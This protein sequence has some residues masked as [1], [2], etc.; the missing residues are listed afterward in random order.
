MRSN[1]SWRHRYVSLTTSLVF[2]LLVCLPGFA[3]SL[4]QIAPPPVSRV[5]SAINDSQVVTLKGHVH[6][7]AQAQFDQG[8]V[9]DSTAAEHVI[10]MLQRSPQQEAA[11]AV[12]LDQLHNRNSPMFH[13]WL[14]AEEFGQ[15]FGPTTS[16]IAKLTDWLQQKGFTIE[17]VPPGR[18][19]ITISG[20]AGQMRQAFNAQ[21]H[22]LN[23]NGEKHVAVLKDPTIP[24]AL[25]PVVS[26]FR[27]L[28]DWGPKPNLVGQSVHHKNPATG[29][30]EKV[31]G[32]KSVPEFT[33]NYSGYNNYDVTPQDWY[34][35]YNA[36][37][38]YAAGTTGAGVTIAVLEETEVVNQSDIA[39]FRSAFGLSAYPGTPNATQGGINWVYGPGNGCS[40]PAKP[41]S[42]GEEGEALLDAEWSGAIAPNAIV[43]FVA[44]NSTGSGIGTYGT[45]LA[46][47]YVAN[48][49]Y[50]TVSATSLSYGECETSAGSTGVAYYKN[51]WQQM[52]AEGITATVSSGD[53]GS[54]G[55]DQNLTYQR[56]NL[57]TNAMSSSPY[58][59]SA[60]GTDFSDEYQAK[61]ATP[62]TYWSATNASGYS[63]A[64]SYIPEI[65]WGAYCANPL[66][67]SYLQAIGNTTYTTTYTPEYLCANTNMSAYRA[68]VGGSGGISQFNTI[69]SW[70]SVYG[71]GT[72]T[73]SNTYRNEPDL[74]FF[75]SSGWWGHAI[76]YCQS[77]AGYP[78]TYSNT[79]D[80]YY[81]AAGGTSFVA[82]AITGLMGL[83]NQKYGRQGVANYTLYNLAAQEYGSTGT[84]SGSI[85]NCS[86]SALGA[87]VGSTCVFRDVA[88]DTPCLT[89]STMCGTANTGFTGTGPGSGA[90]NA[91]SIS[92]DIVQSCK[93]SSVTNCYRALSTHTY[94]LSAV[95]SHTT[96]AAY[97]TAQGYDL[98]TGLGSVNVANLVNNWTNVSSGFATTTSLAGVPTS[99]SSSTPGT[100]LTAT[101]VATGR[102]GKVAAT[103]LVDFYIDSTSGTLLGTGTLTPTCTGSA[104][105]ASCSASAS[106]TLNGDNLPDGSNN[107]IAYFPGDGAND[108]PSTSAAA[109]VSVTRSSQTITF[110]NPGTQLAGT[111]SLNL[112]ATSTSGLP[113]T[114]TVISGAA[115]VSGSV[116]TITG[117]GPITVEADQAAGIGTWYDAAAPVQ[118]TF[119]VNSAP[120]AVNVSWATPGA[121]TYPT[122]LSATQL[123]AAATYGGNPVPGSFA[124]TPALGTVLDGG[125]Q[126]LSVTFTPNNAVAYSS[127]TQTVQI[128]V[129]ATGQTI[130]FPNPGPVTFGVAPITLAA[131]SDSGL[132]IT[133]TVISGPATI[134]VTHGVG[135]AA[136]ARINMKG[137]SPSTSVVGSTLT[138]TGAG[139]VVVEADQAGDADYTAA[140]AVQDSIVVNQATPTVVW[141]TPAAITY[142]TPLSGTQLNATATGVSGALAGS[143]NYTPVLGAVLDAG[144][145]TLSVT[146][147]PSDTTDYTT[148]SL[149]VSLQVNAAGQTITFPNPGP[150]TFGVAP[151]TLAATSDSGLPITYTVISGPATISVTHGVGKAAKGRARISA[152]GA[153]PADSVV[154]STLTIT[155]AGTV[156]VEADQAGDADYTA[157]AA[158]QDSI[159]VNQATPTV[160]WPTPAAITYPA[161]LS[162]TQLNATATGVSG[163]LA[164]SFNYTPAAGSV[165]DAGLQTLS[166][167][168]TPSDTTDYTTASLTV[169]LQVNAAG[170]T[171][172]FPNPGPVT[173]GV[174]PIT[175]AATSD[176]GLPI[177]YTVV[178]GPATISVTHGVGKAAKAR[179]NMKGAKPAVS[180]V[181]STLTITGA[182]TVVVEADQAGD[183][184]YTAAAPVQD[185]IVV[186]Q[187]TP[188]VVWPTPAA[189]TY[190]TPLSGT[191]L[192]ATATGVSGALAGSFNY[193]PVSGAV[194]DVGSQ[195]LSVT[196][197]PSDTTDYTTASLTVSLQV[198]AAGQTITFPNPGTQRYGTPLTVSA[199]ASS[200]LAVSFSSSTP[201]ICS[202]S[203]GTVNFVTL[204]TCTVVATQ[205]GNS[206]YLSA[207]VS[208]SFLVYHELQTIT[209]GPI[210]SQVAGTPV[211]LS[212]TATSGLPVSFAST[213][214][215]VCTVSGTTASLVGIGTCNIVASQVGNYDVLA[216]PQVSRSLYV[217]GAAQS[218]NLATV[219]T[220]TLATGTVNVT[221]SASSGLPVT[222]VSTTPTTCSVSGTTVTMIAVGTCGLEASAAG[223]SYYVA[224]PNVWGHFLITI[225]TQTI[226]FAPLPAVAY[227][228][229]PF[230]LTATASSSLPVSY[231][232]TPSTVCTVSGAS[233]SLTGAG[234]CTITAKQGGNYEYSAAAPVSQSF[235]VSNEAQT[236]TFN[237]IGSQVAG[238]PLT[239]SATASSGLPVSFAPTAATSAVCSVSGNTANFTAIGTCIIVAT[240]P[241]NA[242]IAAAPPVSRQFY[243]AGAAQTISLQTVPSTSLTAGT[244]NL[245]V[246]ASSGLAVTVVS[247]TPSTCSV[248]GY[249]VTLKAT[250]TCGLEA[251]VPSNGYYAAA[252]NVWSNF[253]VTR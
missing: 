64:L 91:T 241:G 120:V 205:G 78:C 224:A 138:I 15:N 39:S 36:N 251:S 66:F 54:A 143:F 227:S 82:P 159:V 3:Q 31:M 129:N 119:S 250:G 231:T 165:L 85:A 23:V 229:T 167:T 107:I 106:L 176:S 43:D 67:V 92:S 169:S 127:E 139:T 214:S 29:A 199:S 79:A 243:V 238:T 72:G 96:A 206:D 109:A 137:A 123:D 86:G 135:K 212:A 207:Q 192:N 44:C 185:S 49:L 193:T 157:A 99:L 219:P 170:Q 234:T 147:T 242:G 6:P 146:F 189:I 225:A 5:Q 126:T 50:S 118:D 194:L 77:D 22:N 102:G 248:A 140:A 7:L 252:P 166:V 84:A 244:V 68:V 132:P 4:S 186:N 56:T 75:A 115:S 1:L 218:I 128:Q 209:F 100:V 220:T 163:A 145:Q 59:I 114:Y 142:G 237:T 10:L 37:P 63:S 156:V 233:V 208:Q 71:V 73:V 97:R 197:T 246:S 173:F 134:S 58:N 200:G 41:T 180:V 27:Q 98:A 211:A 33:F 213:T 19:H 76:T 131:T 155:G 216:A 30:W 141:P 160:V 18:T 34:T 153:K 53:A 93:Y 26:G 61:N 130:T 239:L 249:T 55:C 191:Q 187:A 65:S 89:G 28:H 124:Y 122:A 48:Y 228:T 62:S 8:V 175:L 174:A 232:A 223:N 13:Q 201:S 152:K 179:S 210:A 235:K 198:N 121:I 83:I 111:T 247:T 222:V 204:G 95:G 203:G 202:V 108:A 240:Q 133:Y 103:G 188:T 42:T 221:V 116:L 2:G 226:T 172:T 171:I 69:P 81:Q 125:L 51:V 52:A 181:G 253:L 101:V 183:A 215:A 161:A 149:T 90:L 9:A 112:T 162:G 195:S 17:D 16:D 14:T 144:S 32:P 150:V 94:G 60:G 25:A 38:A 40:A 184:D 190:G 80:A 21:F 24:A 104:G 136:R 236:I 113:V 164:G 154:G 87:S 12:L 196:F 245:T 46:A 230:N 57:S 117:S 70:Q 110:P 182:G 11:A 88:N 177:T 217:A 178:S 20:T 148:A 35:I 158:V 47:A 168:F 74:S 151:I 45:D 105:T